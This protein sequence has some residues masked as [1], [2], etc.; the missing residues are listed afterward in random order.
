MTDHLDRHDV[1]GARR[2]AAREAVPAPA[3][4]GRRRRHG[5]TPLAAGSRP[6]TSPAMRRLARDIR[7]ACRRRNLPALVAQFADARG[8]AA[9]GALRRRRGR[10]APHRRR[11]CTRA[12]A[13]LA[14][15]SKSMAHRGDR[16]RTRRSRPPASRWSRPTSASTSS[17]SPA[18]T[19]SHI[20]A[21]AIHKTAERGAP[22]CC[23]AR[24]GERARRRRRRLTALARRAAA[25]GVP[26]GRHRHHR[27]ATSPS[28]RPASSCLVTNEGNGRLVELAAAGARRADGHGAARADARR[29]RGDAARCSR[30]QRHRPAADRPT[31]RSSPGRAAPASPTGPEELHVV[32]VD[33][34][35]SEPARQRATSEMLSLHPL[36]RL[37]ERL[38]RLPQIGGHAYG[39]VY[40]RPD[41]RGA[42][43]RCSSGSSRRRRCRTPRR[44]AARARKPAR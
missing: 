18:S 34:G 39:S 41:R 38:P 11:L 25:R 6:T 29:P 17:S 9:P 36:R 40:S 12:G 8:G 23:S 7:A 2:R 5:G 37:P 42:R 24:A 1:R 44:C 30:A 19:R 20:I 31:R 43:R 21:P 33:N 28:P 32:I 14:V 22:S 35:R 10:G 13:K 4:P 16:A 26:H 3:H 15:K 27:R